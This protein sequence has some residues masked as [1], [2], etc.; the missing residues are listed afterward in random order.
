MASINLDKM[1][2]KDLRDLETKV[3]KAIA[4]ARQ[5]ERTVALKKAEAAAASAGFSL[6]E[7]VGV[8]GRGR[9]RGKSKSMAKYANPD[10]PADTWTG[11][12]RKPNWLVAKLSKGAKLQDFAI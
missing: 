5:R 9:P 10:N 1:S 3:A 6:A 7:L 12:G 11:R 8:R 2:L 4:A